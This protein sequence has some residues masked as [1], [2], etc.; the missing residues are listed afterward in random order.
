MSR[1]LLALTALTVT[2]ALAACSDV[3]SPT[4]P[5]QTEVAEAPFGPRPGQGAPSE[6]PTLVGTALAANAESGEFSTLIAALVAADLVD[7]LN[8]P[9]P[10]TVFAP[11]DAAF[12][13]LGLNAGNIA[14]ALDTETLTDILLYHVTRGVRPSPSVVGANNLLMLNGD[15][16]SVSVNDEGAFVNASKIVGPDIRTSNG[17]IHI[18]DAVLLPAGE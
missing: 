7:A 8:G 12:A 1:S 16:V 6:G 2:A 18:I 11:T 9:R 4:S 17:V 15:R 10:Y 13:A 3:D 5:I 14:G